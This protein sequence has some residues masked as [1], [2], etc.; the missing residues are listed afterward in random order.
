MQWQ[1]NICDVPGILV[2]HDTN[3]EAG[4]GCTVIR[5]D[6]PFLGSVDVRGGGPA[7]R[8]TDLLNPVSMMQELHAVVLT[9]GSAYG[10]ESAC[11][12]MDELERMGIGY[13]VGPVKVPIVPAAAIFDLGI[14]S[15]TVRPD[16]ESGR[17]A[18][19]NA[20]SGAFPVGAVG[21]GTGATVG[22][23]AGPQFAVKSGLG[24]ASVVMADGFVIGAIAAVNAVGDIY[25]ETT[26]KIL[27]GARAPSGD[28]WMTDAMAAMQQHNHSQMGENTTIAVIATNAQF[29]KAEAAKLAQMA[30]D[31]MALTTRPAHTPHDGDTVFAAAHRPSD[32]Y[33]IDSVRLTMYGAMAA[34]TLASA[35]KN[36]VLA[37][38][39][40]HGIP[41]RSDLSFIH[42]R[43]Q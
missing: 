42:N 21:A 24:T 41:A 32:G 35:I 25:D 27:A 40:L 10:L 28:S 2:G 30:H 36:A 16:K 8:E 9:G 11:G 29:H 15:F 31:G 18:L 37:A 13:D 3:L 23:W 14:G 22:K 33:T 1:N 6:G 34:N 12:V 4:T 7:T 5:F 19:L 20:G 43:S 38:Q 26:G 39:S 17:R